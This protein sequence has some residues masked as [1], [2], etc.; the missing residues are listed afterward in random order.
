LEN[1]AFY[2]ALTNNSAINSSSS[3][4]NNNNYSSSSANSSTNTPALSPT[5][6]SFN[7]KFNHDATVSQFGASNTTTTFSSSSTSAASSSS[8]RLEERIF[9]K[10][11]S[12]RAPY[13]FAFENCH[14]A[15]KKAKETTARV[16]HTAL[17][18][19]SHHIIDNNDYIT[20]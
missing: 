1:N 14:F 20:T 17:V 18:I 10:M 5:I 11:L 4:N 13:Y 15:V 2:N 9:P 16:S 3:N 7:S 8:R 12:D 6:S 19:I